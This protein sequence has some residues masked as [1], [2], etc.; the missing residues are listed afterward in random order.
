MLRYEVF[1]FY[2]RK[3]NTVLVM[4]ELLC[5]G[6]GATVLQMV[7]MRPSNAQ[8]KITRTETLAL[9]C[10]PNLEKEINPD[11]LRELIKTYYF[12]RIQAIC[13]Q[14]SGLGWYAGFEIELWE[15]L[16]GLTSKGVQ[17]SEETRKELQ[18][19]YKS[20]R[21]WIVY[22]ADWL[23]MPQKS[24]PFVAIDKW[25]AMY[26]NRSKLFRKSNIT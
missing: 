3:L 12:N 8:T 2:Y 21:L 24:E 11:V 1:E 13:M 16:N 15:T 7:E 14:H 9:T 22:P 5:L 17:I 20:N 6:C 23:D 4:E 18:A 10:T 26:K 19:L 25:Q